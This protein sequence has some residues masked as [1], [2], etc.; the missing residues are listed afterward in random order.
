VKGEKM[1]DEPAPEG[2][3]SRRHRTTQILLGVLSGLILAI[4]IILHVDKSSLRTDGDWHTFLG[5]RV[6]Y[7]LPVT[8]L[9]PLVG[10]LGGWG[11]SYLAPHGV[12]FGWPIIVILL[13][14]GFLLG[15]FFFQQQGTVTTWSTV[16]GR[17]PVRIRET[18]R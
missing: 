5:V 18:P 13:C 9:L 14:A 12:S 15:V 16:T 10:G 6:A 2:D 8:W 7:I 1:K 11:K 4:A 17:V 3:S